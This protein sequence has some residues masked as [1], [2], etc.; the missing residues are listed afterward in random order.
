MISPERQVA[1]RHAPERHKVRI[2]A[3][4]RE[5]GRR[6]GDVAVTHLSEHECRLRGYPLA[7]GARIWVQF[8]GLA[9]VAATVTW[10]YREVAV[11][12]FD[13]P[14]GHIRL[15]LA[16]VSERNVNPCERASQFA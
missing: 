3:T 2:P 15:A 16:E 8:T 12:R 10:T 11:C 5:R 13:E 1:D 9:P 7:E 4:A 14:L 6:G